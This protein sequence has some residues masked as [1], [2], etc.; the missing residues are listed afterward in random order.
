MHHAFTTALITERIVSLGTGSY[1]VWL[2]HYY[3]P[4]LAFQ[5]IAELIEADLAE[6][7]WC[8]R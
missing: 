1:K 5:S 4:A 7:N 6:P 8:T 3:D 2:G